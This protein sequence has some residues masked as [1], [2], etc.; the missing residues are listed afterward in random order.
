MFEINT[1]NN[2]LKMKRNGIKYI[3]L[4]KNLDK[5]FVFKREFVNGFEM[6]THGNILLLE[7]CTI[8]GNKTYQVIDSAKGTI[9]EAKYKDLVAEKN[10]DAS[11]FCFKYFR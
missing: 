11:E 10:K 5:K 3:A 8:D 7:V 9:K 1:Q 6:K 2:I 4:L